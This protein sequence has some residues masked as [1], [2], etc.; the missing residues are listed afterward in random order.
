[1]PSVLRAFLGIVAFAS[2]PCFA[3]EVFH[4]TNGFDLTARSHAVEGDRFI[5]TTGVGTVQLSR[6]E[7]SSIDQVP[8]APSGTILSPTLPSRASQ[9]KAETPLEMLKRVALSQGNAPEFARLVR[10]VAIAESNLRQDAVSPK[11][12]I[13]MM[14]L[15]PQTAKLLGVAATDAEQN[16]KGGAQLLADLLTKYQFDSVRAVA[17]YNAG[18]AAVKKYGGLP[19]YPET[20]AYV[21]RV[22]R[23]Y[24]Q[25]SA[26]Q[27]SASETAGGMA[28]TP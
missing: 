3:S 28:T 27:L 26:Q 16:A 14:Q 22:L 10:S 24:Q 11:G 6:S 12:A 9:A 4:L 8:D 5:L 21:R 15:M 18:T 20:Q 17:A 13:G 1:M 2:P 23:I 25:L 19:P 7:I